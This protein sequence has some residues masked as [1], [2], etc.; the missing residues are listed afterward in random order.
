MRLWVA[1]SCECTEMILGA[2]ENYI[3]KM[4]K[5]LNDPETTP[6]T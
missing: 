5:K 3:K 6:E 2:K 4:S 1:N